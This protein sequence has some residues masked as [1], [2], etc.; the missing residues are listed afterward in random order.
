MGKVEVTQGGIEV[1]IFQRFRIRL[2]G[3]EPIAGGVPKHGD[4]IKAWLDARAKIEEY[5]ATVADMN[6]RDGEA[7]GE[8]TPEGE[9][10]AEAQVAEAKK[11]W[12]GFRS[13]KI[14]LF[15]LPYNV[16]AMFKEVA[17]TLGLTNAVRG[18]RQVL[19]HGFFVRRDPGSNFLETAENERIYILDAEGNPVKAPTRYEETVVHAMTPKGKISALKRFD[20]VFPWTLEF[21]VH[22]VDPGRYLKAL[23]PRSG[24]RGKAADGEGV[25][26]K[27]TEEYLKTC[28]AL[29]QDNGLGAN[30]TA[31]FGTFS[32]GYELVKSV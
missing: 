26:T 25:K 8:T 6:L 16:N 10:L 14:G 4:T 18:S 15:L 20:V 2:V 32:A 9:A 3:R 27:V 13:D 23:A 24:A 22:V 1:D 17:T 28:L 12:T 7:P 21:G 11:V 5:E 30:R 31:G 19:Q 29:A